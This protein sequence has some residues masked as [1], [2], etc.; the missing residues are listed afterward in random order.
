MPPAGALAPKALIPGGGV[1]DARNLGRRERSSGVG[2]GSGLGTPRPRKADAGEEHPGVGGL[3]RHCR[4]SSKAPV[5]KPGRARLN[6]RAERGEAPSGGCGH[7]ARR[8]FPPQPD[9]FQPRAGGAKPLW[10]GSF[11]P[12]RAGLPP[13]AEG[14]KSAVGGRRSA[15]A[16]GL[17]RR[18]RVWY[19]I[20]TATTWGARC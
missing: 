5:C 4:P 3:W 6:P 13:R 14:T 1:G 11:P 12:G 15:A 7:P 8:A 16:G 19:T 18:W 17:R 10:Q 20:C 9:G 2:R